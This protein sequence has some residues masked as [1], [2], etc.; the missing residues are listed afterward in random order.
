MDI[1]ELDGVSASI[2]GA[3]TD[4]PHA[5]PEML[6]ERLRLS[7]GHVER[8]IGQLRERELVAPS[9]NSEQA[10]RTRAPSAATRARLVQLVEHLAAVEQNTRAAFREIE[11]LHHA[12]GLVGLGTNISIRRVVGVE[13]IVSTLLEL[14]E[15]VATMDSML[16]SIPRPEILEQAQVD[17]EAAYPES[18]RLR[19]IYPASGA[20]STELERYVRWRISRGDQVRLALDPPMPLRIIDGETA[21]V[22]GGM[23]DGDRVALFITEPSLVSVLGWVFTQ[24]WDSAAPW[25]GTGG[26]EGADRVRHILEGLAQGMSDR[27]IGDRLGLS[28]R[29]VR[30]NISDLMQELGARD[31]F[32]LA[33]R[34]MRAGRLS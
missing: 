22:S 4:D 34:A 12:R 24:V 13:N 19:I 10:V 29:T 33:V 25:P 17:E 26:R 3:L 6:A 8:R 16:V 20:R 11:L 14:G 30:R 23:E 15:D 5:T 7:V 2:Y 28:E 32:T 21:V 1:H 18:A 9:Q 27:A 31:R